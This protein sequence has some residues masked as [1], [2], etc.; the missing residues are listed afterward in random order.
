MVVC[1]ELMKLYF[2]KAQAGALAMN[3]HT[4]KTKVFQGMMREREMTEIS[5]QVCAMANDPYNAHKTMHIKMG[6]RVTRYYMHYRKGINKTTT[7]CI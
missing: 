2:S 1:Y 6:K 3:G 4:R 7:C 5:A